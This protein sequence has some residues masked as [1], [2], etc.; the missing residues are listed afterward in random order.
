[1]MVPDSEGVIYFYSK[2]NLYGEFSNFYR[3]DFYIDDKKWM[4]VEHFY[5]ASKFLGNTEYVEK[6]RLSN[7]PK[8]ARQLGR[9]RSVELVKDWEE[10]KEQIMKKALR[11]KFLNN[12]FRELLLST[13]DKRLVEA[14]PYDFYWGCG[15]DGSGQNRLGEL[16]MELREELGK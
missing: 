12:K 1:M 9:S 7:T 15:G 6:I 10:I 5:Q 11:A 14:S 13:E 2:E 3:C 4:T 8:I 16:L